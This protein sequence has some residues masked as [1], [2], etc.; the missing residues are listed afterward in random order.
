MKNN[1][2]N[3]EVYNKLFSVIEADVILSEQDKSDIINCFH[4]KEY[5]KNI[6]L[7]RNGDVA[8]ELFF[9][10]KGAVHQYYLDDNGNEKSC[11]FTF[12]NEFITDLESFSKQIPATSFTVTLQHT[13][14]MVATCKSIGN[15]LRK[16]KTISDYFRIEVEKIAAKSFK[17]T[18]SLLTYTP[19]QR[20]AELMKEDPTIFQKVPQRYIAQYIGVAPES[21]SRLKKR[22]YIKQKS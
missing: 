3:D 20:F 14:C 9:I 16:N 2:I 1:M 21:L 12:E 6:F 8:H 18:K 11:S 22:M 19:E 13:K 15:L 4:F 7:I 5:K 17:R 10:L